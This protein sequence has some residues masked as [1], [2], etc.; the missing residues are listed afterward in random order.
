MK[1]EIKIGNVYTGT[2]SVGMSK[3]KHI[4]GTLI[5][6]NPQHDTAVLRDEKGRVHEVIYKTLELVGLHTGNI[7][8]WKKNPYKDVFPVW[9]EIKDAITKRIKDKTE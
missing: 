8:R 1:Q 2:G 3:Y 4:T 9:Y 6:Y 5:E 7:D